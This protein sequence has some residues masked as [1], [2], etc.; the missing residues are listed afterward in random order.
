MSWSES[1][2]AAAVNQIGSFI[3]GEDTGKTIPTPGPVPASGREQR[4][5]MQM[6]EALSHPHLNSRS[7]A[8]DLLTQ[9]PVVQHNLAELAFTCI[10]HWAKM[11][12]WSIDPNN[13]LR[14][15]YDRANAL[16]P[17][18]SLD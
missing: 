9:N 2:L 18:G 7:V 15:I 5:V 14:A 17:P 1:G 3:E 12:R 16:Y 11:G 10:E 4:L 8:V 6:A 13:P